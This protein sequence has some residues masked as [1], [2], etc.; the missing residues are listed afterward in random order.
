MKIVKESPEHH[1][2][3]AIDKIKRDSGGW[4]ET[5]LRSR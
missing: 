2:L 4:I 1:F 5:V 3:T